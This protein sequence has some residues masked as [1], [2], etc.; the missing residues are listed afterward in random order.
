MTFL[1]AHIDAEYVRRICAGG[2]CTPHRAPPLSE[3]TRFAVRRLP[4]GRITF[5]RR[6][7]GEL[8]LRPT[9]RRV[10]TS[11]LWERPVFRG[12]A[13]SEADLP[14]GVSFGVP[15]WRSLDGGLGAVGLAGT[16]IPDKLTPLTAEQAAGALSTAYKR[17]TGAFPTQR[18]LGL[19][20]AQ[21]A[22]ET[23]RWQRLH[24]YGF[25]NLKASSSDPYYQ[26]FRCWEVVNG[27]TVWYEADNPM[28]RF[29]AYLTAEDGAERYIRLLQK[30]PHWWNGLQTGTVD[31]F[32]DGLTTV[33]KFFTGDAGVYARNMT[34][35]LSE[36]GAVVAEYA[37][38][39]VTFAGQHKYAAI[40]TAVGV[41]SLTFGGW[42]LYNAMQKKRKARSKTT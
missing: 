2:G 20:V 33:P 24:N 1:P 4:G 42:Y 40:G 6:A 34:Q 9:Y 38:Q 36:Y 14:P 5:Q 29:A 11:W 18:I 27:Q 13:G 22:Q 26:G 28:C 17:V 35:F 23:G 8:Y 10:P 25:G 15:A 41:F 7:V 12:Y 16:E 30:R 3:C 39:A 19:L 32:I 21:T 37:G 31:G